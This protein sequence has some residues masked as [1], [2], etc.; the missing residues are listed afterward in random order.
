MPNDN[1]SSE[2][3]N[4]SNYAYG[5]KETVITLNI[6]HAFVTLFMFLNVT[7][8]CKERLQFVLQLF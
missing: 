3:R 2:I 6:A 4:Y 5:V 7:R 1:N 8:K